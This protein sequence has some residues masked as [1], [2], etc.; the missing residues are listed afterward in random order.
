ME[1]TFASERKLT[2]IVSAGGLNRLVVFDDKN[3]HGVSAFMTTDP[4]V[5]QAIR[6]NAMCR[7]SIIVETTPEVEDVLPVKKPVI[8]V[9]KATAKVVE[10]APKGDGNNAAEVQEESTVDDGKNAAEVQEVERVFDNY[11]LARETICK[12]FGIN[13]S[14]VRNPDALWRVAKEHGIIIKYKE[15]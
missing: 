3:Q 2:F 11:T 4:Q 1:Y 9:K 6:K 8:K 14:T 10:V 12:E 7:R 13:K 5:A 15:I